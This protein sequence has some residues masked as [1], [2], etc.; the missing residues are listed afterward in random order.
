M[1][2]VVLEDVIVEQIHI[3]DDSCSVE[4]VVIEDTA[5]LPNRI[6]VDGVTPHI[7]EN[8]NWFIGEE[9]TGSPATPYQQYLQVTTDNPPL[10]EEDW[11]NPMPIVKRQIDELDQKLSGRIDTIEQEIEELINEPEE[12]QQYSGFL[13]FPNIGS[14]AVLYIDILTTQTYRWDDTLLKYFEVNQLNINI[15]NG[16]E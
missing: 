1:H 8:G 12:I 10:S 3:A 11:A 6:G 13:T 14:S 2:S 5:G 4:E 9:D 16:G 15:I 7:G